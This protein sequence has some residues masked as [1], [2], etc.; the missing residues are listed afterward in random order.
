MGFEPH[1]RRIVEQMEMPP[2]GARQTMLFSATFPT[3]IQ[4]LASDIMSNYIFLA[5]MDKRNYLMDLLHTQCDNGAHGKRQR[6]ADALERWLSMN[7][8][9]ATTIHVDKVQMARSLQSNK[10][11]L[12]FRPEDPYSHPAFGELQPCNNFLLKI[13]KKAVRNG[14]DAENTD[15]VSTCLSEDEIHLNQ[16]S[17]TESVKN[18]QHVDECQID[19][20][21]AP[22]EVKAQLPEEVQ[23]DISADIVARV[24]EAYYFNER[25]ETGQI[26]NHNLKCGLMD[27]DQKDLMI[28]VP[29]LFSIKD[30]PEKVVLHNTIFFPV[31]GFCLGHGKYDLF[32]LGHGKW[33]MDE[34]VAA[35]I[36][37]KL[38]IIGFCFG[39]GQ[40]IDALTQDGGACFGIGGSFYGTRIDPSVVA[41]IK[42]PVLFIVGDND[43]SCL[44]HSVAAFTRVLDEASVVLL[45]RDKVCLH[46]DKL[47]LDKWRNMGISTTAHSSKEKIRI[48]K[49]KAITT[50]PLTNGQ[51][52]VS[53][54]LIDDDKDGKTAPRWMH[55]D[56]CEGIY[57]NP[58]LY[59]K[60]WKKNL[61]YV[62][63]FAKDGVYDVTKRYNR[64]W[65]EV[66]SRRNITT[67]PILSIILSNIR[68]ECRQNFASQVISALED[69]DRN[70][71]EAL[72]R[73]LHSKDDASISLPGR[74]TRKC[75]DEH[76]TRRTSINP[77]SNGAQH[78]FLQM[79]PS[80]DQL[81]DALSLKSE[82]DASGRVDIYLVADPVRTSIALPVL[83]HAL[84]DVIHNVNM[85]NNFNKN[86]LS[87][88]LQK[89]NRIYSG[90]V[91]ASGEELSF[92]I[93]TSAFD[94][95]RMSKWEEPNG[96]RVTKRLGNE[97]E[98]VSFD[99]RPSDAINIAVICKDRPKT[100]FEEWLAQ[101]TPERIAKDTTSK[102]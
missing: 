66:L 100:L 21:T 7:G 28:L 77:V 29:P 73:E 97:T 3:E 55:L 59:E 89:L 2:P 83:F 70:E 94:G 18:D 1:I 84:D 15:R 8:F 57:D 41:N 35:G 63:A 17:C 82:L 81:F 101:Q 51:N 44:E 102:K 33:M 37:K 25:R 90:L 88:P 85:C 50:G 23:E 67:E 80:F 36:S 58:L 79:L 40:L 32:C 62:I 26:W 22:T 74:Q 10:L 30:V 60:G 47:V 54:S 16:K 4:R 34:F 78:L 56:P 71:A 39:G 12:H 43:P 95:T 91:L 92:G 19:S 42:V 14:Q 31:E 46:P 75:I 5:D 61:N 86:S 64:K 65:H 49:V 27:V 45:F 98:S 38:G 6:G 76:L 24:S 13:T 93:V 69:Q 20:I 9:L 96:A 48:P 52:S 53:A 68:R 11:G 87:W 99:L 72:E